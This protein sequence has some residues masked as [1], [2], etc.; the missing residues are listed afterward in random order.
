MLVHQPKRLQA[1]VPEE[2]AG[3]RFDQ[4]LAALFADYSRS[5]IQQWIKE[6]NA[7]LDGHIRPSRHRVKGGELAAIAPTFSIDERL[8]PQSIELAIVHADEH[9]VV[10]DKPAGLVVHPGAGNRDGTSSM[11]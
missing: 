5:R 4:V 1:T 3:K 7:T 9:I 8:Q 11:R 10:V 6:G 2:M